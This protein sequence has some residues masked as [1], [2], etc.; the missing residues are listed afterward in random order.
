MVKAYIALDQG[1]GLGLVELQ[2]MKALKAK[3]TTVESGKAS[4]LRFDNQSDQRISVVWVG[5]DGIRRPYQKIDP[6]VKYNQPTY[7]EHLWIVVG[8]EGKDLGWFRAPA[9]DSRVQ[10]K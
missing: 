8:E 3:D 2:P 7:G 10:V 6:G 5:F 4:T 9:A 1:E